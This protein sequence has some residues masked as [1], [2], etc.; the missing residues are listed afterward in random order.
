MH[1]WADASQWLIEAD[2]RGAEIGHLE[3]ARALWAAGRQDEAR[4]E[5]RAARLAGEA[6]P[7]TIDIWLSA[8]S[9]R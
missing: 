5:L 8:G 3:Q 7:G 2:Q 4:I 6:L 1:N 9:P